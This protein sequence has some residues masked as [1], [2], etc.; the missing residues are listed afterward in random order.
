[1]RRFIPTASASRSSASSQRAAPM[2]TNADSSSVHW[3]YQ[4]SPR[5]RQRGTSSEVNSSSRR[6]SPS[7]HAASLMLS[8]ARPTTVGSPVSRASSRARSASSSPRSNCN[9]CEEI[10]ANRS[11]AY[12][13][14]AGSPSS[15]AI[16]SAASWHPA[17]PLRSDRSCRM[18]C[19]LSVSIS[20]TRSPQR[21]APSSAD[22]KSAAA[23][24]S[25]PVL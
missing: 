22:A 4:R 18:P 10:T 14:A 19:S 15:P 13:C 21:R 2:G 11:S 8:M 12:V 25:S 20:I 17:A 7:C 6:R 5:S 3:R 16:S 1:M 9:R 24:P 23:P